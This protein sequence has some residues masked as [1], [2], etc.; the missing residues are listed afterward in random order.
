MSRMDVIVGRES[1]GKTYWTKIGSAWPND[2]GGFSITL[3]ALPLPNA[4]G[5]C[6]M[7]V[8]EPKPRDEAPAQ[9]NSAR[10]KQAMG[11][12]GIDD[13]IPF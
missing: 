11:G 8:V 12:A 13:E 10:A 6:R 1:N 5:V 2:K 9:S 7:L 3:D 4:E